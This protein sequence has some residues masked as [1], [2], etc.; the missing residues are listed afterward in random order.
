ML[1]LCRLLLIQQFLYLFVAFL[2]LL[3]L[4]LHQPLVL[5]VQDRVVT[6][7]GRHLTLPVR[8]CVGARVSGPLRLLPRIWQEDAKRQEADGENI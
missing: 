4:L 3:L 5:L 7:D 1:L 2:V 8:I 6:E